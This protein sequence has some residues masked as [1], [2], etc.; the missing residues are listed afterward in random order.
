MRK[1]PRVGA[2]NLELPA[3]F[4][5]TG[6]GQGNAVLANPIH[7]KQAASSDLKPIHWRYESLMVARDSFGSSWAP[8][9]AFIDSARLDCYAT[10]GKKPDQAPYEDF[11][12]L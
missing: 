4:V 6:H 8:F 9:P 2:V 3:I 5:S 11:D 1:R 12:K 10:A 7:S